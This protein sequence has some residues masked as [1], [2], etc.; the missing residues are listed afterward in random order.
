[1]DFCSR[2]GFSGFNVMIDTPHLD[3]DDSDTE[4]VLASAPLITD[5]DNVPDLSTSSFHLVTMVDGSRF[6]NVSAFKI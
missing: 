5:L 4:T 3:S 6:Y 2:L 1:M